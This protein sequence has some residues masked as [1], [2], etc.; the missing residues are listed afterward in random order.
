MNEEKLFLDSRTHA[1]KE[2]LAH[3]GDL[4]DVP[5]EV[6]DWLIHVIASAYGEGFRRGHVSGYA[7]STRKETKEDV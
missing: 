2:I 6:K 3:K 4:K 1:E 5:A 7:S